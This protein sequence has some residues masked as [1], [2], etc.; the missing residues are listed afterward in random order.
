MGA[1][2]R[3]CRSRRVT[4][5]MRDVSDALA[6]GWRLSGGVVTAAA[7]G[8][9]VRTTPEARRAGWAGAARRPVRLARAWTCDLGWIRTGNHV[10]A[11]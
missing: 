10:V 6:A 7:A 2:A 8:G 1:A 5:V 4:A 9:G 3:F 11:S